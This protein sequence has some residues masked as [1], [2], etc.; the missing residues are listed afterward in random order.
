MF[1]VGSWNSGGSLKALIRYLPD[2]IPLIASC[3]TTLLD[4]QNIHKMIVWFEV[5][6]SEASLR[7]QMGK[8]GGSQIVVALF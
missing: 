1:A 5:A 3:Y 8:K 4:R 2:S 7:F 6:E